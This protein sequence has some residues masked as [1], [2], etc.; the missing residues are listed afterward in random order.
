MPGEDGSEP[1][2]D[3]LSGMVVKP[4]RRNHGPFQAGTRKVASVTAAAL[5]ARVQAITRSRSEPQRRD[6]RLLEEPRCWPDTASR[7]SA[8]QADYGD[9]F[10]K[11]LD[12]GDKPSRI[13]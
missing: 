13:Q 12:D 3:F 7:P 1:G 4:R 9:S 11:K 2:T 8:G 10:H 5:L 6:L